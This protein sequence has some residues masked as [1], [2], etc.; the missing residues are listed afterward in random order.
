MQPFAL[1]APR[2]VRGLQMTLPWLSQPVLRIV[3]PLSSFSF[4]F[5]ISRFDSILQRS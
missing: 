1:A 2:G 5:S 3:V 4:S